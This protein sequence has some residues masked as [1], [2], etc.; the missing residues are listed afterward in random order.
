MTRMERAAPSISRDRRATRAP[1]IVSDREG[2]VAMSRRSSGTEIWT[3]S[4]AS[5]TRA[6]R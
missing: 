5:T 2:T 1:R 6:V 4:P 3:T